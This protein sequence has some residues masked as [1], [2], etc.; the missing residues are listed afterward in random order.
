VFVSTGENGAVPAEVGGQHNVVKT[1]IDKSI[2][3]YFKFTME[4]LS[5]FL[6]KF[7]CL[8]KY[9]HHQP[10]NVSTAG[11]QAFLNHGGV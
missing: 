6:I 4:Q 10:I 8:S 11:A 3:Y 7:K 2:M 1:N 5:K 9:N